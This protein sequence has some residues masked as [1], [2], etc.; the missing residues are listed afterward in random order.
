[1]DSEPTLD[2]EVAGFLD[3]VRAAY[4][5]GPE[6][7]VASRHLAAMA[8]EAELAPP[9]RTTRPAGWRRIVN[10]NRFIR[11]AVTLGAATLA[12]VMGTAGLAV[13]GVNVPD[14]AQE[15]FEQVGINLPNQAGGGESGE[16]RRSDA[17]HSVIESTPPSERDCSFGHRVAEA[18]KGS[19]LPEQARAACERGEN[20]DAQNGNGADNNNSNRS[21]FG[22]DT[23]DRARGLGGATVEQRRGFGRGTGEQATELGGAPDG[24]A[25]PRERPVT[26]RTGDTTS[27]PDGM[28][29]GAPEDAPAAQPETLPVPEGTPTGPPEDTPTGRP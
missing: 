18:A 10:R 25:A 13:A 2:K 15:A 12:A 28:P 21:Q 1:M 11:P 4:M 26:P 5:G 7:A 14:P 3:E 9:R 19:P 16:H 17:V 27:A 23:A 22:R 6:E 8:R 24:T 20:G 29:D